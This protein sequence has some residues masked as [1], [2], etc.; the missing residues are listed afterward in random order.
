MRHWKTSSLMCLSPLTFNNLIPVPVLTLRYVMVSNKGP[1][2]KSD[3]T[4]S[5]L[6]KSSSGGHMA[7]WEAEEGLH[8]L[9][10]Y[11]V[12]AAVQYSYS[13]FVLLPREDLQQE[14][15]KSGQRGHLRREEKYL[16]CQMPSRRES[17]FLT[18]SLPH[19][20]INSFSLIAIY[21]DSSVHC[22][23]LMLGVGPW[24]SST[25]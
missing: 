19:S 23:F 21:L 20:L 17:Y 6:F 2:W 25:C 5:T 15:R 12:G 24:S 18:H 16:V 11:L 7:A 22:P 14:K 9:D 10:M 3:D 13:S 4:D 8:M 1:T